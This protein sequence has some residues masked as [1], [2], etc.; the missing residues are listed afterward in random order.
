MKIDEFNED[1]CVWKELFLNGDKNE[2][3]VICV[4]KIGLIYLILYL[5]MFF[6]FLDNW[7]D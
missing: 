2:N 6:I 4:F 7:N 1:N 5:R 3:Y